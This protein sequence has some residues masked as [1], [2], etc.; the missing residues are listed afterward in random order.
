MRLV[1]FVAGVS[2]AN[3]VACKSWTRSAT[4]GGC[5]R[6]MIEHYRILEHPRARPP[7]GDEGKNEHW[8]RDRPIHVQVQRHMLLHGG[9]VVLSQR[10]PVLKGT[11]RYVGSER[12]TDGNAVARER[13]RKRGTR[14]RIGEEHVQK[15]PIN[16]TVTRQER[17]G[18]PRR[19]L[20]YTAL[21]NNKWP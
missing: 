21:I 1:K 10:P 4:A 17:C 16:F 11:K 19:G 7:H 18:S 15:R 12:E 5:A 2:R 13:K 20:P 14:E 3:R 8:C 6:E 9:A